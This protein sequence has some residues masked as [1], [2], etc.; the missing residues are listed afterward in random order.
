MKTVGIIGGL[1]PE[2]TAKFYLELVSLCQKQRTSTRPAIVIWNVPLPLEV[3][4]DLIL[5]AKGE[6]RY[7][8]FL[9]DAAKHLEKCG[10]D[11]LVMPC[12]S[13][14][15]F[16]DQIRATVA[17]PVLSIVEETTKFLRSQNI[18]QVGVLATMITINNKLY[19]GPLKQAGIDA[20]IPEGLDQ[21]K[22]GNII[23]RLVNGEHRSSDRQEILDIINR[24]SQRG[25]STVILACTDLQLLLPSHDD[26]A[27]FDTMRIFVEST[28]KEIMGGAQN[29]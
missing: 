17:I 11:F 22:M 29:D 6:E 4:R 9:V 27:I 20:I 10:A 21:A 15:I 25:V 23:S 13:L 8:P 7:L 26:V 14:H 18:R 28:A 2:T 5:S 24:L 1:G 3:E 12:N 16:I 19:E